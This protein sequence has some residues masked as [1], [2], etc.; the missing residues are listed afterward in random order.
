MIPEQSDPAPS[1]STTSFQSAG[2]SSGAAK[3][4]RPRSPEQNSQK[5]RSPAKGVCK[6]TARAQLS[7]KFQKALCQLLESRDTPLCAVQCAPALG[8]AAQGEYWG[9][10]NAYHCFRLGGDW[11]DGAGF[12]RAVSKESQM[13]RPWRDTI[14]V[15]LDGGSTQPIGDW[16]KGSSPKPARRRPRCQG[17]AVASDPANGTGNA[18]EQP[19]AVVQAAQ[20]AAPAA[21]DQEVLRAPKRTNRQR[22]AE[23]ASTVH[24]A[25][26]AAEQHPVNEEAEDGEMTLAD[27]PDCPAT[28]LHGLL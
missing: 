16:L 28:G 23:D 19:N 12:E 21:D 27:R 9:E 22:A 2:T 17:Q 3:T 4:G 15:R 7:A 20:Q 6:K 26:T 5:P 24:L 10:A 13:Q 8:P 1:V 11:L 25:A 18:V 14:C